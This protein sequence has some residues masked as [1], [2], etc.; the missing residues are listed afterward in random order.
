[1]EADPFAA[2]T[3]LERAE[4]GAVEHDPVTRDQGD[5][6]AAAGVPTGPALLVRRRAGN[7]R[8]RAC[9]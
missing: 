8:C 2:G 4:R 5:G 3:G 7:P 1:M 6:R 9:R